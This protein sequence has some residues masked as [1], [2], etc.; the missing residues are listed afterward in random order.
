M[1]RAFL[2]AALC[3]P[4]VAGCFSSSGGA[5]SAP[6]PIPV[7]VKVLTAD[8]RPMAK[9]ELRL[10]PEKGTAG[11]EAIGHYTADGTFVIGTLTADD[12]ATPGKYVV[13][14]T[15]ARGV[16]NRYG[17]ADTSDARVIVESSG[18]TVEVKLSP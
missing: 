12:G 2:F 15:K 8:G 18:G 14:I 4:L 10:V 9:A 6:S 5:V 7:S 11:V 1:L 3:V 13:V 17:E 16:N